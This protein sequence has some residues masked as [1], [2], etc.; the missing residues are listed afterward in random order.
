MSLSAF[1]AG[2]SGLEAHSGKLNVIGNNLSNLN[3][4]GFKASRTVFNDIFSQTLGGGVRHLCGLSF[5]AA[6]LVEGPG[7]HRLPRRALSRLIRFTMR[8]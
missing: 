1:W 7:V 3:T 6:S 5:R 2:L 4:V 8:G